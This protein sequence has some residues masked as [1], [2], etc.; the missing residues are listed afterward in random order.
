VN[1][2]AAE[3]EKSPLPDDATFIKLVRGAHQSSFVRMH[4]TPF[5]ISC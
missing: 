1:L 4:V 2:L 3:F 5:L